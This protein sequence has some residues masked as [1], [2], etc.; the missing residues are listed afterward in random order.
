[1]YGNSWKM[2]SSNI[3]SNRWSNVY[4]LHWKFNVYV[5]FDSFSL[6][7][8]RVDSLTYIC[9][10]EIKFEKKLFLSLSLYH[11]VSIVVVCI[12]Q[13]LNI[14]ERRCHEATFSRSKLKEEMR[15]V[16]FDGMR[17]FFLTSLSLIFIKI[18]FSCLQHLSVF[19]I[20]WMWNY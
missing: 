10:L 8:L 4:I 3:C 20:E 1:M 7:K 6:K 15:D 11:C 12:S 14:V 9:A 2:N 17:T 18:S 13:I 16:G 5:V 19:A